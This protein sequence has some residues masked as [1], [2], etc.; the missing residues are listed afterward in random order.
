M[1]DDRKAQRDAML[2]AVEAEFDLEDELEPL[3]RDFRKAQ[4][5][6]DKSGSDGDKAA[7]KDAKTAFTDKRNELRSAQASNPYHPRQPRN[8]F[9]GVS[10][11]TVAYDDGTTQE[12]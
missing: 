8:S 3:E 12:S 10:S 5:K 7:Y 4:A 6:Y 9:V 11:G 1:A 2:A